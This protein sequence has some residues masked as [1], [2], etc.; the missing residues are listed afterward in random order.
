M[1]NRS[2]KHWVVVAMMCCLAAGS[3]GICTNA[4][5]VFY[6]P[7]S[8]SLGVL[9]GSFAMHATLQ[10]LAM[11]VVTLIVPKIMNRKNF[12]TILTGGV[13]L[14]VVTTGMMGV[15]HSLWMFFALGILRGIGL[16]VY[17]I[18]P[19]TMIISNWF[20][21]KNGVATSIALS[22]S[23]LAGAVFSPLFSFLI[24]K[25]GWQQSYFIQAAALMAVT[26]PALLVK[27]TVTPKQ[28]NLLPHGY[29]EKDKK[30]IR[31]N[32]TGFNVLTV[33]F[34]CMC[35]FSV[36][37]T[38]ITGVSQ[39]LS[40]F[41]TSIGLS[42]S[43]GAT[44]MSLTMI[45]NISTKLIIGI[46][47]DRFGPICASVIMIVANMLSI[48]MLMAGMPGSNAMILTVG[49]FVFGSV[50]AVGAVGLPLLTRY[51]F[52]QENYS[53][54][55]AK[56]GFLT[57]VGSSLSLTLIGYLYDFTGT[58]LYMLIFAMAFHIIDLIL[59]V[60]IR[61]KVKTEYNS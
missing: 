32:L 36:L 27:W 60:V 40:G 29:E 34:M 19:L 53:Q 38:S 47:S 11:A 10:S 15:S 28:S 35:V 24:S 22:F 48:G 41:A 37:H 23:G 50:Y 56:I 16:G 61:A 49:S 43:F 8:D 1:K 13:L 33:S 17:A 9:R 42:A 57:S 21:Q 58:Y 5:G 30:Q 39:H 7:V 52:V 20:D 59:I 14:S 25:V 55:Y 18:V 2:Y 6:T 46:I 31:I 26:L 45:G 51:F 54:A 4:T 44:L 3:I 12:K